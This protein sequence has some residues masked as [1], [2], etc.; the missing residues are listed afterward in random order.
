MG[1]GSSQVADGVRSKDPAPVVYAAFSN[2]GRRPKNE[3]RFAAVVP[4]VGVDKSDQSAAFFG[5]YDGHNG[6]QTAKK[7]AET[8][9]DNLINQDYFDAGKQSFCSCVCSKR[10]LIDRLGALER[11]I[12]QTD[13]SINM[14]NNLSGEASGST[15]VCVLLDHDSICCGNIG[16][17]R[18]LLCRSRRAIQMSLDHKPYL[19]EEK[20]RIMA[21]GGMIAGNYMVSRNGEALAV[22][23]AV[24]DVSFRK[25]PNN[26]LIST[27][28]MAQYARTDDDDFVLLASDGLF[29]VMSNQA[30]CD[31]VLNSLEDGV[32]HDLVAERLTSEAVAR[33]S[34]DNVTVVIG[35]FL[36][37]KTGQ[38]KYCRAREEAFASSGRQKQYLKLE[39]KEEKERDHDLR[40]SSGDLVGMEIE[41]DNSEHYD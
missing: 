2:T 9:H 25:P 18:A 8:V 21:A 23:R 4:L 16:D 40:K 35:Y 17:A 38:P 33:G 29:D 34:M 12:V 6:S 30:V 32:S 27:P 13:R 20:A 28:T 11:A 10:V 37:P 24:G 31:F 14:M 36:D 15:L 22:S 1:G 3:D 5:V 39:N 26:L 41:T 7:L 19:E